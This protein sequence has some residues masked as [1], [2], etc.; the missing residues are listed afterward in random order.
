MSGGKSKRRAK[1]RRDKLRRGVP[2]VLRQ[3]VKENFPH[4]EVVVGTQNDGIKM[5]EVMEELVEP[6]R[7]HAETKEA[8]RMLLTLAV[9]AWNMTLFPEKKRA[10]MLDKLIVTLPEEVR[11]DGKVIIE[12]LMLR[13]ER[14]FTEY[15]RMIIDFEVTDTGGGWH[16]SVMSTAKPV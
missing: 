10:S 2:K 13:K 15:R 9:V 11:A 4:Q 6:Y 8:Y 12:E 5:S 1:K 3:R 14:F 16:L 7:E